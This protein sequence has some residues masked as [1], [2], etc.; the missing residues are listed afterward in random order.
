MRRAVVRTDVKKR[1][2]CTSKA[3]GE[4]WTM[5]PPDYFLAEVLVFLAGVVVLGGVVTRS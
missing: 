1:P 3:D 5:P 4:Q 2:V